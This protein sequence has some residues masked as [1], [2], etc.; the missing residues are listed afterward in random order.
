M[1]TV[2]HVNFLHPK[3]WLLWVLFGLLRLVIALPRRVQ[4]S[5]SSG[6]GTLMHALMKSRRNIATKNISHCF[7]EKSDEDIKALVKAHFREL[8]QMPLDTATVW[9][10][11]PNFIYPL[12][13]E[14]RGIEHIQ[15]AQAQGKPVLLISGHFTGLDICGALM[16]QFADITVTYRKADNALMDKMITQ[17]REKFFPAAL[18]K[19]DTRGMLRTLKKG[20]VLWFAPDQSIRGKSSIV[21]QFFGQPCYSTTAINKLAKLTGAVVLPYAYYREAEGYVLQVGEPLPIPSNDETKDTLS[22]HQNLEKEI[23]QHPEQYYWVHRK[24]NKFLDY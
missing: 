11:S 6:L 4:L 2:F 12:L 21:T 9:W 3:Y 16:S 23:L 5:F 8:A 1:T 7:P 15:N 14:A 24:F 13:K 22:F 19:Q 17:G 18:P 20:G 10:K